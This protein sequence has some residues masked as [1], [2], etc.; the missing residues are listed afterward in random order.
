MNTLRSLVG[1]AVE[2]AGRLRL[3]VDYYIITVGNA[4][5]YTLF[6]GTVAESRVLCSLCTIVYFVCVRVFDS[7]RH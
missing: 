5:A 2:R 6:V 7:S 4:C 3:D 1:F